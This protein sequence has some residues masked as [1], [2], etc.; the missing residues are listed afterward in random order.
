MD[1]GGACGKVSI[2][3]LRLALAAGT[4]FCFTYLPF[5]SL[6]KKKNVHRNPGKADS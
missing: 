6:P 3:V 1:S 2:M 4:I 5:S